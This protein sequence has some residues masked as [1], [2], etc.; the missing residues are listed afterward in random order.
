[1]GY[2]TAKEIPNYWAYAGRFILQD[3]CSPSRRGRCR[4]TCSGVGVGRD[5]P[6][7]GT[8]GCRPDL[9]F[10]GGNAAGHGRKMWIPADGA[11]RPYV[12]A[13]ITWLLHK[14]HV[15]WAYYVGSATC[16]RPGCGNSPDQE[17]TAPVQN[18]LPGFKTVAVNHQ[19]ENVQSNEHYFDAAAAG[20]LPKVSWVMPT[21]NRAS[22]RRTTSGT[23]RRG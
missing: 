6:D 16:L 23:A 3:H 20:T 22:T 9:E 13:D 18:T 7:L 5:V 8:P 10:P 4:R 17:D 1:M 11:P 14:H 19:L 2:H 12:W 15:S 21:T